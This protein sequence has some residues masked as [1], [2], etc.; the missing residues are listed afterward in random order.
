MNDKGF[1]ENTY[2]ARRD[3]YWPEAD[4]YLSFIHTLLEALTS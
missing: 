2:S 4:A 1:L 3:I